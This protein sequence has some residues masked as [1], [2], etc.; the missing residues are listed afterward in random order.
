MGVS[1]YGR[2][3]FVGVAF[4]PSICVVWFCSLKTKKDLYVQN[5]KNIFGENMFDGHNLKMLAKK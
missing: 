3:L 2:I 1:F 4:I 5:V